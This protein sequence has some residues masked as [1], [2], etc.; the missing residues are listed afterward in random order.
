MV[1]DY[2]FMD[3]S[4]LRTYRRRLP[5]WRL[6]GAVYF[7][8][9]RLDAGQSDLDDDEREQ[10]AAAIRHF[11]GTRYRLFAYVVMNDHVH[12]L[13]E[14]AAP[15]TLE[16]LAHSWKSYS[17]NGLQGSKRS[18]RI[19]Q[20]EYFDRIVRDHREL[21]ERADYIANNPVARWPECGDYRWVWYDP[22][23]IE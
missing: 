22:V 2:S 23:A 17:A 13:V 12:V 11:S 19:W 21:K 4:D 20:P 9:W 3:S 5:H 10:V 15:H 6:A 14:P 18:G 1:E 16:Q 7:V 8:T